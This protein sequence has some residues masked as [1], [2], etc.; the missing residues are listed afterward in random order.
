MPDYDAIARAAVEGQGALQDS[1]ELAR[2]LE[3]VAGRLR[4]AQVILEI[5]C[6][7]GGTLWA[8]RT[9]FPEAVIVGVD[10]LY[11]HESFGWQLI[12]HGAKVIYGDSTQRHTLYRVLDAVR[13]LEVGFLHID[14]DHHAEAVRSD[15]A[16][17]GPLVAPGGIIALHDIRYHAA[18]SSHALD[19]RPL[20]Q[21]K[22]AERRYNV[23]L[24][25]DEVWAGLKGEKLEIVNPSGAGMGFGLLLV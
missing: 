15:L 23:T 14:G 6:G 25:V 24:E 1:W 4:P 13:N 21:R 7:Q 12:A 9:A 22:G 16:L 10:N 20:D 3:T 5:G 19:F 17:Y 2:L 11:R 18:E 8:W